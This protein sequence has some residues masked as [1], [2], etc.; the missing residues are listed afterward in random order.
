MAMD[1]D[2]PEIRN[3]TARVINQAAQTVLTMKAR[4]DEGSFKRQAVDRLSELL[5]IIASEEKKIP[6]KIIDSTAVLIQSE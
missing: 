1:D 2:D 6:P 3:A 5:E 4:A